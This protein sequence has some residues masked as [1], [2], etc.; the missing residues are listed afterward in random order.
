M[1]SRKWDNEEDEFLEK[2]HDKYTSEELAKKLGR[3]DISIQQRIVYL[4]NKGRIEKKNH[5]TFYSEEE[6]RYLIEN[7]GKKTNEEMSIYLKRT[8]VAINQQIKRLKKIGKI[9]DRNSLKKIL[10]DMMI[11]KKDV[12]KDRIL[13][14][15]K[16][17]IAEK[18]GITLEDVEKKL[19]ILKGQY[20]KKILK[21]KETTVSLWIMK[22][23]K[24][25][26]QWQSNNYDFEICVKDYWKKIRDIKS[27]LLGMT[28][29]F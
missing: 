4:K 10:K 18:M 29:I 11:T 9:T 6:N 17:M 16:I 1:K 15:E 24:N 27:Q 13:G 21:E 7:Y 22:A 8:P 14:Y 28:V 26:R 12:L 2:N 20:E 19:I 25:C 23:N 5:N 3:T